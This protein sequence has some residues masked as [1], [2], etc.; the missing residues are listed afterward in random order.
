MRKIVTVLAC[1]AMALSIFGGAFVAKE[2]FG[3][4]P[5]GAV[6]ALKATGKAA[7]Q[8]GYLIRYED[9]APKGFYDLYYPHGHLV[10]FS[11]PSY[12]FTIQSLAICGNYD[13]EE[14]LNPNTEKRFTVS[15]WNSD[16]SQELWHQN[17][18]WYL[19]PK[20]PS[21]EWA[22]INVPDIKVKDGF[23]VDVIT[24]NIDPQESLLL[25]IAWSDSVINEH[26]SI[27]VYGTPHTWLLKDLPQEK[28][29][30]MIRAKGVS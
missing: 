12:P 15:I 20:S 14:I 25:G 29:N 21:Y 10:R 7:T 26:S 13:G 19:F 30:W 11:P 17:F 23:Y 8:T 4:D 27:S 9:G 28:V 6:T 1:S 18:S 22:E 5:L 2:K 24:N 3:V 16:F